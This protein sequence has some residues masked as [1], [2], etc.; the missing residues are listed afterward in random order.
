MLMMPVMMMLFFMLMYLICFKYSIPGPF[1]TLAVFVQMHHCLYFP[2]KGNW[3]ENSSIWN[4]SC[5]LK[6]KTSFWFLAKYRKHCPTDLR[7]W[8]I[9]LIQPPPSSKQNLQQALISWSNF[10]LVLFSK[11]QE[12]QGTPLTSLTNPT[13]WAKFETEWRTR[14]S[15]DWTWVQ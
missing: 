5:L 8:V 14:Q 4:H 15:N 6:C 11:G 10:S 13:I 9:W 7:H 3:G 2:E 12:I 1:V